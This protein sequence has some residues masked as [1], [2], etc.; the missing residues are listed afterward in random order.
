MIALAL[1][2]TFL[3][4][5]APALRASAVKP[6]SALKGGEDP[7]SRRRLMHGLVAV[8]VAFCFL[9][10]FVAG[11][12]V[13][14]FDRLAN[15]P[16]GFS[17]ERILTLDALAAHPQ[18][19]AYWDQVAEQIRTVPGVEA[20]ALCGWPLLDGSSWNGFISINRGPMR[21][22][23]AYLLSISPQWIDLMKIRFI[24]GRD[25]RASDTTPGA[26][27]VNETFAK[28]FFNGENPIGRTFEKTQG[29]H[30]TLRFEIVGLVGDARYRNPREPVPPTAYVP[31]RTLDAKG[32]EKLQSE[33]TFI[34]RTSSVN[35]LALASILRQEVPRARPEFRVTG[36]RTQKEINESQTVRERLL[37]TLALFFAGVALL[38]ASVGLYGVLHYSVLQRQREI[39]IRMALGARAGHIARGV[40]VTV[41]SM[42]FV[43][44]IMGLGLGLASVRYIESLFY[45][46]KATDALMLALPSLILF[47][48]AIVAA[49]PPVIRAVRIDPVTILRAE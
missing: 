16:N 35:P 2:V 5:L 37:A 10:L 28:T 48:A 33:G 36:I 38:L 12:F 43:G 20:V 3:F 49:L 27:I 47:V 41:F 22:D 19:P 26:A 42:V 21:Q 34:V 29:E 11:L 24:A 25:F 31:F 1:G 46:V 40:T 14:T 32:V 9:V 23:L 17:T 39:A 30:E 8:Q 45:Q 4:G 13:A 18:T 44:A 6:V 15:Q 7:H